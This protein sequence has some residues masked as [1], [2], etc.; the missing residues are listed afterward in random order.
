MW[1]FS[2]NV[3]VFLCMCSCEYTHHKSVCICKYLCVWMLM[4]VEVRGWHWVSSSIFLYYFWN[5]ISYWTWGH[6]VSYISC[7][8]NFKDPLVSI[9]IYAVPSK[10]VYAAI[11]SILGSDHLYSGLQTCI[12]KYFT[13]RAASFLFYF[14]LY[15]STKLRQ[16]YTITLVFF[17]HGC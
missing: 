12:N 13:D 11:P 3:C 6:W 8:V 16:N 4:H 7:L 17:K 2:F 15:F 9:L 10:Q 1:W 5:G 14:I